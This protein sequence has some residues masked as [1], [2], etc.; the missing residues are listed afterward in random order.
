MALGLGLSIPFT[1]QAGSA[2]DPDAAAYIAAVTAAGATVSGAQATAINDFVVINKT[3]GTWLKIGRL[4]F[5][6]WNIA[7]ANALDMKTLASGTF[8][9]GAIQSPGYVEGD[10]LTAYFNTSTTIAQAGGTL[11]SFYWGGLN[12]MAT[13]VGQDGAFINGIS[14]SCITFASGSDTS[15]DYG[16][17]NGGNGR[18][19][20]AGLNNGI[21]SFNV[22]GGSYRTARRITAGRTVLG[23]AA[24]F[25]SDIPN[26][27]FFFLARNQS[28]SPISY[29]NKRFGAIYMGQGLS[30]LEDSNFTSTLKTLWETVTGQVLL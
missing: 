25:G 2:M 3:A 11:T 26:I 22:L 21:I 14:N 28:G 23:T 20:V 12:L 17:F 13:T 10:G 8:V 27:S 18:L 6:V 1:R 19:T 9:G 7:A 5:P 16:G 29:N 4:Y 30:D 15:F 24:K